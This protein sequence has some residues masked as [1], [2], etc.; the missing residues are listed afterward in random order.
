M[1]AITWQNIAGRDTDGVA[2]AMGLAGRSLNAGFDNINQIGKDIVARDN[3]NWENTKVNNTANRMAFIQSLKTPEALAEAQASGALNM[4]AFGAQIDK[5]AILN[6][7]DARGSVLQQRS[8]ADTQYNNQVQDQKEHPLI[9]QYK[10]AISTGDTL[11]A[12]IL[13]N[14]IDKTRNGGDVVAAGQNALNQQQT[15]RNT[16]AAEVRAGVT[17]GRQGE[18]LASNIAHRVNQDKVARDRL[19]IDQAEVTERAA[20]RL[21]ATNNAGIT[22]RSNLLDNAGKLIKEQTDAVKEIEK[23]TPY[24]TVYGGSNIEDVRKMAETLNAGGPKYGNAVVSKLTGLSKEFKTGIP[25]DVIKSAMSMAKDEFGASLWR[26]DG[27]SNSVNDH[28]RTLM[29][30]PTVIDKTV[31]AAEVMSKARAQYKGSTLEAEKAAPV[32]SP[33]SAASGVKPLPP[34]LQTPPAEVTKTGS[35]VYTSPGAFNISSNKGVMVP[36]KMPTGKIEATVKDGDTIGVTGANGVTMD[37]RFNGLDAQETGKTR[38][39]K[40]TPG[41]KYSEDAKAFIA[42]SIKNGKVDIKMASNKPDKYGRH[43][44]DV[45]VNGE[46]LNEALLRKGL[47]TVLKVPGGIGPSQNA[48]FKR[49]EEEAMRGNL[50][51][52]GDLNSDRSPTGAAYRMFGDNLYN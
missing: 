44:A 33:V 11:T 50:G 30:D 38:D 17:H 1:A 23:G 34:Q 32:V 29:K 12:G 18:E 45:Y 41:Q 4:D 48:A 15:F 19:V 28:I 52:L 27:Y 22:A 36:S 21:A 43:L 26:S 47:A 25:L 3:A 20:A 9:Q 16:L 51:I 40:T 39:G 5:A 42:E 2:A 13:R 10:S 24:A 49:L 35:L 14:E 31:L 8:L 6:T 37:F 7:L 46:S